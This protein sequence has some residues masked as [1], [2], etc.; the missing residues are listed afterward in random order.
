LY[1]QATKTSAKTSDVLKIKEAFPALDANK[2]DQV[3]NI[4][5]GNPKP[6]LRIQMMTKGLSRKQVI[7]P[8]SKEN[9]NAFLKNSSLHVANINRQL[10]NVKLEVL[11]DYI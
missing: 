7:I 6:K 11:A 9:N 2:I 10:C 3:N 4:V 1:A 5:K 8:I